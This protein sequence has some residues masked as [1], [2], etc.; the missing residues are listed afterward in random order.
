MKIP[1]EFIVALVACLVI[2]LYR[3]LFTALYKNSLL[4]RLII[5]SLIIAATLK[6]TYYGVLAAILLFYIDNRIEGMSNKKDANSD[7]D[8]DA[9]SPEDSKNDKVEINDAVASF[10]NKHCKDGKLV[11]KDGKPIDVKDLASLFPEISFDLEKG[12]TCNPCAEK[13]NFKLTS[14]EERI[15]VEEKMRPVDSATVSTTA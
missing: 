7:A 10:K 4:G 1:T 11:G 14:S 6:K 15:T 3:G 8:T 5:V 2:Y 13:C 12:A 9:K